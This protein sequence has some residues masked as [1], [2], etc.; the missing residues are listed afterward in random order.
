MKLS[1]LYTEDLAFETKGLL[2]RL[3]KVFSRAKQTPSPHQA[4]I[5]KII[6]E[7]Y[8][9]VWGDYYENPKALAR[10]DSYK[11]S[12][13]QHLPRLMQYQDEE[14]LKQ[15]IEM[16]FRARAERMVPADAGARI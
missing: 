16:M 1:T 7:I 13:E 2:H 5:K 8:Q 11:H 15:E 10:I 14:D 6:E 9:E 4:R 3:S 12:I